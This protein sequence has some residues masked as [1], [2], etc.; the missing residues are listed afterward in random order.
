[1]PT[2]QVTSRVEIDFEEVLNGVARLGMNELEQLAD[3]VLA[4]QAQHR[5]RS[6]PKNEAELLQKINQGYRLRFESAMQN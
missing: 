2:V 5:A 6:L 4:L 3:K 1:M